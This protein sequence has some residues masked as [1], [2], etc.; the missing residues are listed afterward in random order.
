M[1]KKNRLRPTKLIIDEFY[2]T[3]SVRKQDK[4]F[5][6]KKINQYGTTFTQF[7]KGRVFSRQQSEENKMV[8]VVT[9]INAAPRVS[10]PARPA[11]PPDPFRGIF[12]HRGTSPF[13]GIG[14]G[15]YRA[16]APGPG[17]IHRDRQSHRHDRRNRRDHRSHRDRRILPDHRR[18][19]LAG[20]RILRAHPGT[21]NRKVHVRSVL[22]GFR[23]WIRSYPKLFV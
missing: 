14:P 12:P 5:L 15:C 2:F 17:R 4:K 10:G 20:L 8:E 13:R 9:G 18:R 19:N 22:S 16:P 23:I 3:R 6:G 7:V 21:C 11:V 1:S